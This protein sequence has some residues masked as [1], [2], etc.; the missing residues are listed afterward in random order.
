M[1]VWAGDRFQLILKALLSFRRWTLMKVR[2]P[3]YE[4]APL[5][6]PKWKTAKRVIIDRVYLQRDAGLGSWRGAKGSVQMTSRQPPNQSVARHRFRTFLPKESLCP[7]CASICGI[8]LFHG[9]NKE[10]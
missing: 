8:L 3:R 9:F 1:A 2:M 7:G 10:R 5:Q 6:S 4:F